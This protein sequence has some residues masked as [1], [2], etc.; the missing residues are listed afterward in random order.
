MK[1]WSNWK[2]KFEGVNPTD[3][4]S[5]GMDQDLDN[6]GV[7]FDGEEINKVSQVNSE[8]EQIERDYQKKIWDLMNKKNHNDDPNDIDP[9]QGPK[10]ETPEGVVDD[11]IKKYLQKRYDDMD[12]WGIKSSQQR[13]KVPVKTSSSYF[14]QDKNNNFSPRNDIY[15]QGNADRH[16]D[17]IDK[18]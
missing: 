15:V 14:M 8:R 6:V 2:N 3:I 10:G 17:T 13:S 11:Q 16:T 12:V 1:K 18:E 7:P 4:D 9:T 5:A